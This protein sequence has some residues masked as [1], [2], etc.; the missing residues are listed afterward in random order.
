M[1]PTSKQE[2]QSKANS[3]K[4]ILEPDASVPFP[5]VAT[6]ADTVL[7]LS[8]PTTNTNKRSAL[9]QEEVGSDDDDD[10]DGSS[11]NDEREDAEPSG[12]GAVAAAAA[13][14]AAN[15]NHC[16]Y[17]ATT[18]PKAPESLVQIL[19]KFVDGISVNEFEQTIKD[20]VKAMFHSNVRQANC[21]FLKKM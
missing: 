18:L 2:G 13:P 6:T 20:H 12:T 4:S 8:F 10:D 7:P 21:H 3:N 11:S 5:F 14:A 15:S 1:P 16:V 19:E 17:S 9:T